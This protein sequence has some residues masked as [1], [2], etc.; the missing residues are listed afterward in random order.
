MSVKRTCPDDEGF[1]LVLIMILGLL[2]ACQTSPSDARNHS[3]LTARS[4]SILN[5]FKFPRI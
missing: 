2:S 3:Y 4:F 1:L 5:R